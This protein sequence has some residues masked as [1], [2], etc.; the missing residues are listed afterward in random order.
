MWRVYQSREY[1]PTRRHRRTPASSTNNYNPVSCDFQVAFKHTKEF[2]S[3]LSGQLSTSLIRII[4]C[5][6]STTSVVVSDIHNISC[7]QRTMLHFWIFTTSTTSNDGYK[8]WK[9]VH[10]CARTKEMRVLWLFSG[11]W[12]CC[13]CFI[14]NNDY[15]ALVIRPL[16]GGKN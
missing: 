11:C 12:C 16:V 5:R 1:T 7:Y 8:S 9:C 3:P 14:D 15:L 4:S 6:S 10:L 2:C 13:Y